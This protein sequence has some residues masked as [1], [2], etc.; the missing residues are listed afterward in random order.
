MNFKEANMRYLMDLSGGEPSII[1]EMVQLFVTQT[2]GHLEQLAGFI[3]N[4]DW[5]NIRS[6]AHHIKPTLSYMGAED[7]RIVL[8]KIERM[9]EEK[10][11]M[12]RWSLNFPCSA[13]A[14]RC[15]LKNWVLIWL[16]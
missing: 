9:A 2:P 3:E 16:P 12:S 15:Y 11:T 8:Q 14:S 13:S 1:R 7:M 5:E 6:M 4:R 10:G